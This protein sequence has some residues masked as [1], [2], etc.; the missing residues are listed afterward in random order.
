M[1]VDTNAEKIYVVFA[2][3]VYNLIFGAVAGVMFSNI[4]ALSVSTDEYNR[5]MAELREFAYSKG[6]PKELGT[7]LKQFKRFLFE[8]KTVFD[9]RA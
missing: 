2:E 1:N 8:R 7:Q 4:A 5:R 6:L 9:E 3:L